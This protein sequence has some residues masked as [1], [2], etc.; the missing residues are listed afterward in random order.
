MTLP[1]DL[2]Q[3]TVISIDAECHC[4]VSNRVKSD[5]TFRVQTR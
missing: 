1:Q 3:G 4:K 5:A 2:K